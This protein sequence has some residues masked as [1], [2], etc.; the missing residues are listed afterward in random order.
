VLAALTYFVSILSGD[1]DCYWD[2]LSVS[3]KRTPTF[4]FS[5]TKGIDNGSSNAD[6]TSI[7]R[8]IF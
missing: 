8:R 6:N 5:V 4:W 3:V 1:G 2:L 7:S